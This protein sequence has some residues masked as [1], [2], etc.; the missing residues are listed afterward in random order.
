MISPYLDSSA[1]A[2]WYLNEEFSEAVEAYLQNLSSAFISSLTRIEFRCLLAR[3]RRYGEISEGLESKLL[4]RFHQDIRRGHLRMLPLTDE[5]LSSAMEI[6]D[7]LPDHSL[8]TL[9]ALHLT[10][11][12]DADLSA[13]ATADRIMASAAEELGLR[14]DRFF[15]HGG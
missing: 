2:K 7:S 14:V 5:T 8:R 10:I 15:P 9:D 4:G 11:L 1:L 13:L 6:M 12:R 3:R